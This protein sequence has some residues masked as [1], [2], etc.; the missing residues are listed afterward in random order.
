MIEIKTLAE[1]RDLLSRTKGPGAERILA[2]QI[3][4][5]ERSNEPYRSTL[6]FNLKLSIEAFAAR[7]REEK[8]GEARLK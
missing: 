2:R 7:V 3:D 5:Y 6:R 4:A 1:C 8:C